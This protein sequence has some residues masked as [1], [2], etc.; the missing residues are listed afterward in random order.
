M[1]EENLNAVSA[2]GNNRYRDVDIDIYINTIHYVGRATIDTEENNEVDLKNLLEDNSKRAYFNGRYICNVK[3][4]LIGEVYHQAGMEEEMH[5]ERCDKTGFWVS[6]DLLVWENSMEEYIFEE[7][8]VEFR[9]DYY[10]YLD[11]STNRYRD[12]DG[13]IATIEAPD[14]WWEELYYCDHCDCYVEGEDYYGD[15][16]CN[17]C[18]YEEEEEDDDRIIE[19]Y[20]E[21]HRHSPVFFGD[22]ES[23]HF[24]GFGFELE[25]DC[26]YDNEENNEDTA[27]N[28]CSTCG[29]EENEMRYAHDGSLNHGFECISQPHTVKDFWSKQGKWRE[30]LS[31][32]ARNGYTSHD[33]GTC[34][35]HVHVSREM[36]GKTPEEQDLAIAKVYSFFDDNWDDITRISRR[37]NFEYCEKNR[38]GS[39]ALENRKDKFDG[40]KM[41]AKAKG[42]SHCVALNN[43]NS[44]TFEY[45][46]GRGTLN[47]WSFFSWID[48]VL[49]VTKNAK[50]I[51]IGKVVSNDKV[52][53]LGGIRE[54]TAK[55]MYK[56]GAFKS[57]VLALYPNIEWETDLTDNGND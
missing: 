43:C 33:A 3:D 51:A 13:Y 34:G 44:A 16:E 41:V 56:R 21:S 45:R 37:R 23:G 32:L 57:A 46:L 31:Y 2:V 30:M 10:Y 52:S 27:R 6:I 49:T 48:F 24:A 4:I 12:N 15:G 22:Y 38:Q 55:Y 47:A 39:Y 8:A 1:G 17:F 18:H 53:W 35:L 29:L 11:C 50:R 14:W 7:L 20:S 36:F 42:G 19:D 54:S 26:D 28:L 40:W 9:G 25:V 5:I